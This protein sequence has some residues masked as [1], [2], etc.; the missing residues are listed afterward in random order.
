MSKY[1]PDFWRR[2][3]DELTIA[4]YQGPEFQLD[5]LD[6]KA[7]EQ[8]R[9]LS[10]RTYRHK[11]CHLFCVAVAASGELVS[12]AQLYVRRLHESSAC[13]E[14]EPIMRTH[15][16]EQF[17]TPDPLVTIATFHACHDRFGNRSGTPYLVPPCGLCIRRL[18][19]VSPNV[20]V[21]IDVDGAGRLVKVPLEAS[22]IFPHP[23]VH[24]G[25]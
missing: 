23:R 24:N 3:K 4:L 20:L 25:E 14:T 19:Q 17:E 8:A 1:L 18:Q 12:G 10:S 9:E 2:M 6:L 11:A 15:R 5:G 16:L 21:V 7:V 22:L 13:A